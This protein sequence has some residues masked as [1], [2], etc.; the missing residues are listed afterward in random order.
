MCLASKLASAV[1]T[2]DEEEKEKKRVLGS[3]ASRT[4]GILVD[5]LHASVIEV[6]LLVPSRNW[7][8]HCG[9][10]QSGHMS[11]SKDTDLFFRGT[12]EIGLACLSHCF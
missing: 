3:G 9:P 4:W 8:G 7:L 10:F 12:S 6:L 1:S 2:G 5:C 11:R